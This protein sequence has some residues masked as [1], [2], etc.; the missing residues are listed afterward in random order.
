MYIRG[1]QLIIKDRAGN[2]NTAMV[3]KLTGLYNT[4]QGLYFLPRKHRI[5]NIVSEAK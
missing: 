1:T 3:S 4:Y 2:S 5:S